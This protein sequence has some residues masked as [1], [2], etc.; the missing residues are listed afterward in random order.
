MTDHKV[1]AILMACIN[2]DRLLTNTVENM[3][4]TT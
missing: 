3:F 1:R 4:T 2:N